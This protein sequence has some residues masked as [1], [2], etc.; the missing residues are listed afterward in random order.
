MSDNCHVKC[1][2]SMV[3]QGRMHGNGDMVE[4]LDHCLL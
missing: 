4:S 2:R 1:G 3:V